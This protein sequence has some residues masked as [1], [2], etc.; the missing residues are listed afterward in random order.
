[1]SDFPKQQIQSRGELEVNTKVGNR[2]TEAD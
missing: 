2:K 1:M